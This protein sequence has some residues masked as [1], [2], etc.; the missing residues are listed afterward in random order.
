[1]TRG[2]IKILGSDAT[3]FAACFYNERKVTQG[4]AEPPMMMNFGNLEKYNIHSPVVL[5]RYFQKI[6]D[7]NPNVVHPQLHL[8]GTLPGNPSETEKQQF[9]EQLK[10]VLQLLG[11]GNQPV[12]L[13]PH[14]DTGHWHVHAVSVRVDQQTGKWIN[15]WQEGRRARQELDKL[16]GVTTKNEIEKFLSFKF[17]TKEQFLSL[18]RANGYRKSFYDEELDVVNVIRTG[19]LI[20]IFSMDEIQKRIDAT[21][22]NKEK[23]K[24]RI[25]ELR[26]ILRDRRQRSMNYL[27]DNPDV[28]ITKDGKRHTVSE[29]L[30]DVR[31]AAF[32]GHEGLDVKGIRKAQF[33]QFL[34]ELKNQMGIAIVFNQWKDGSTKGYTLIDYKNKTIFKGSDI[35]ALDELLNPNWKKGQQKDQVLTAD[36]AYAT[37]R[38]MVDSPSQDG[39]KHKEELPTISRDKL[40][41]DEVEDYMLD[42]Y[43]DNNIKYNFR[44][45]FE[46]SVKGMD[47]KKAREL[48]FAKFDEAIMASE[49][50][51]EDA[52]D[53]AWEALAYVQVMERLHQD[54]ELLT[55]HVKQQ[56]AQ[57]QLQQQSEGKQRSVGMVERKQAISDAVASMNKYGNRRDR[58][59]TENEIHNIGKGIVARCLENGWNS[60]NMLNLENSL[61][62]FRDEMNLMPF[63][64]ET[65]VIDANRDIL[66]TYVAGLLAA[67]QSSGVGVGSSNNDLPKD[68]D[69][70]W[71]LWKAMFD[72][73][74]P[75]RSTGG[76]GRKR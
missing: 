63:T 3:S 61:K 9:I 53:I 16:R 51:R 37:T 12:L 24:N 55:R 11:Y 10:H 49:N 36:E 35:L 46:F 15:N 39:D 68:K 21:G 19:D 7:Q 23:E 17:E 26:G 27:V 45:E 38:Q 14:T 75:H 76:Q 4:K 40:A 30:R 54:P 5:S 50:G 74:P 44:P 25:K 72:M 57:E 31:G 48:A 29:K 42:Y 70:Q 43:E 69:D 13:Y 64:K 67:L 66:G 73:R 33:K 32:E 71:N 59:F 8:M 6:A 41:W 52:A 18:L 60:F 65:V 47:E 20:H 62:M 34:E 22:K 56:T 2:I 58:I 28:K 1:M